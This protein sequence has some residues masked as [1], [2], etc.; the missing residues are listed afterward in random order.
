MK[1][2]KNYTSTHI[3]ETTSSYI[4]YETYCGLLDYIGENYHNLNEETLAEDWWSDMTPAEQSQYM[5]DH[6][7]SD[8]S[9][10][11]REKENDDKKKPSLSDKAK[12]LFSKEQTAGTLKDLKTHVDSVVKSVGV[13]AKVVA[14]AFKEPSVYNTVNA[15]GGSLSAASKTIIGGA[16]TVGKV[17]DVGGGVI[18]DAESFKKLEKGVIKVDELID[19]NPKL[20]K[21]A[22]AAVAG[23]ATYQ[24]LNMSFSGDIESD[25]D[26]SLIAEGIAGKAGFADLI[27]TPGGVKS[28]ALLAAGIATGGGLPIW[29]S[30][31][32]GLSMALAYTGAKK[33]GDKESAKK[34]KEKM[35]AFGKKA[36]EK[37]QKGAK[38]VDKKLGVKSEGY[39]LDEK[40]TALVNKAKKTG[41][42]YGILKKV[43]DRGMA[44]YK[45]G[46]RPGATPQQWAFARV[47]SFTT[48][49]AGTWGKADKDLA[50][51]VRGEGF[52]DDVDE[53]LWANIHKKRKEG[54]PMRKKGEKGAP[55]AAQMKRA[56]GEEV[57]L[58]ETN[59]WG[60]ITEKSE[61]DGRPVDLNN[62][63]KGDIKK[64]KVYVKNE[65]GNVVKVEFGDPNMEIKR[66]DP[67][68]RKSFRAR[69][70]CDNPGPKYKARYWSCKFWSAKSVTDLMKG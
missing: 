39:Q 42:P 65:K 33:M 18:S 20:K 62:P 61:Y 1:T 23:I 25:Y 34:I 51:Q 56:K 8:K 43:Y 68:R 41:M 11:A 40:I 47:N 36:K 28:M 32:A 37:V 6:P 31:K 12:G 17:L 2:F 5:K 44:A 16:R 48:K 26:V 60:E 57:D 69:H 35:V 29:M 14:K 24:W 13:D 27:N 52:D 22:G 46:H 10:N 55:T 38:A 64:Y 49:S 70:N 54:R 4:P 21:L 45:T 66:D 19:K 63:T 30:G 67:G 58:G 59:E 50:K 3:D 7:N 15:L 9:K 53:S